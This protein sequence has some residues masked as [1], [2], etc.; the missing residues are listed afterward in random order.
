MVLP[1]VARPSHL[2]DII[3]I[4]PLKHAQKPF[5]H[6]KVAFVQLTAVPTTAAKANVESRLLKSN[7]S[8]PVRAKT[9]RGTFKNYT[10]LKI[11]SKNP[12]VPDSVFCL[13]K[14]YLNASRGPWL[15]MLK[16]SGGT[17]L[18][19]YGFQFQSELFF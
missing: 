8:N 5:S 11:P 3:K 19:V 4:M 10:D 12:W 9:L 14:Y 13:K 2:N 15:P 7:S 6:V 16:L 18:L 17:M 1:T